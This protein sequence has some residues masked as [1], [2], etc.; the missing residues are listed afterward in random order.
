MTRLTHS[1]HIN[2]LNHYITQLSIFHKELR[3]RMG[4]KNKSK[5]W[6]V[7]L[8]QGASLSLSRS[9]TK[10]AERLDPEG[11]L[12][13][14]GRYADELLDLIAYLNR[15]TTPASVAR[16]WFDGKLWTAPS[17]GKMKSCKRTR[18]EESRS[19]RRRIRM[20]LDGK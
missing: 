5:K 11:F 6:A 16:D 20:P 9:I 1:D 18:R 13:I 15:K 2:E 3:L 7:W 17:V 14:S 8:L 12:S 10:S 19:I 4:R